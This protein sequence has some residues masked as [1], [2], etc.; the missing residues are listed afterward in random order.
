MRSFS[1][2]LCMGV[3]VVAAEFPSIGQVGNA[4]SQAKIPSIP[5]GALGESIRLGRELVEKTTTHPLS[6]PYSGN[7]LNCTSCHLKNG[8]D[9]Q[10]ATFIGVASAYPAWSPRERRV[11]T[12]ED[13]IL[14]CFMRSC[15]GKRPPLGSEVSVSILTYITWLSSGQPIRM[16]PDRPLGPNPLPQVSLAGFKPDQNKGSQ[17]YSERCASCHGR[18]GLGRRMNPPLWGER[19]YNDGAGLAEVQKLAS[20]LKPSMPPE[21]TDLTDDEALNIAAFINSHDRPKFRLKDH[22]PEKSELGEYNSLIDK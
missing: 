15:N 22:L 14:N 17:L 2:F 13:R 6:K 18:N 10:A 11:I 8:T 16:N 3:L 12:L 20:W 19:S 9:L 5:G 1:L 21:E 4:S 7:A